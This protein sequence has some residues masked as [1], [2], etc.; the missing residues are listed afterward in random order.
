MFDLFVSG[1]QAYNQVAMFLGALICLGIGGLILGNQLYWRVHALRA[2]G[3]IIGVSSANGMYTPVYRYTINGETHEAKSD[4]SSG[5]LKGKETGRVV[6]LLISAHNPSAA[7]ARHDYLLDLIGLVFVVPGVLLGYTALT[8]YPITRMT[9]I[10]AGA[11]VLYLFERGSRIFIPKGQRMSIAEWRKLH[12]LDGAASI[13]L[14]DVKPIE[15]VISAP[16]AANARAAAFKQGRKMAPIVGLFA[17]I[18]LAV[19]VY[20]S[21]KVARL[22]ASGLR[23]PGEVVSLK[24]EES[25]DG[26]SYY[27]IVRYRTARNETVEF[28]DSIGGN[29]PT[30]REGDR[31]TVL[32]LADKPRTEAM[33]DRGSFW[34]WL[35]PGIVFAFAALIGWLFFYMVRG[36]TPRQLTS[37]PS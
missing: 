22:E 14:S 23:A 9:W 7:R 27:P 25:S 18:L 17:V 10:M 34:N 8:A 26:H 21:F 31:V 20:Q 33:I 15:Q 13:D 32:Y 4:T 24:E 3:T 19:G 28:K 2:N 12:N 5:W 35:I 30:R 6:P 36:G 1:I 16:D 37:S 29:P 11:M